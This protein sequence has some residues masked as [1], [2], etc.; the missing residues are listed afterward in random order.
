MALFTDDR[1]KGPL[2]VGFKVHIFVDL[3]FVAVIEKPRRGRKCL[4]K[5]VKKF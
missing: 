5:R 4:E 1:V 2:F 3:V